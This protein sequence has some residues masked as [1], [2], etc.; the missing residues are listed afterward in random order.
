MPK[1]R[2]GNKSTFFTFQ[3]GAPFTVTLGS[4][5]TGPGNPI[6]PNLNINLDLS[7]MTVS[8]IL[9]AGGANLFRELSAGQR[10]GNGNAGRNILRSDAL[11]QV[12]FG[13]I[14]AEIAE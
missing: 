3:S 7:N 10:Y 4:D 1:R 12:D 8:E 14:N 2:V 11:N 5:P 6:R 9:A 13:I